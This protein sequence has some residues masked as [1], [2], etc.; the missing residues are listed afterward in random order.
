MSFPNAMRTQAGVRVNV[1]FW[2]F[3]DTGCRLSGMT[4]PNVILCGS[5][6]WTDRGTMVAALEKYLP[7]GCRVFHGDAEGADRM[8][9][10]IAGEIAFGGVVARPALWDVHGKAA[11]PIR[12]QAMLDEAQP[13]MVV[14]FWDGKSRGTKDML[15]RA[16]KAGVPQVIV[17]R[18][19]KEQG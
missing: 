17:V 13:C 10:E 3:V 2:I 14:A 8:A 19:R 12:N 9:A 18:P 6:T 16:M 15:D 11:G 1:D 4:T 7:Y 5:R